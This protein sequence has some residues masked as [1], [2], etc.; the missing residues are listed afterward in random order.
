VK[1]SKKKRKIPSFKQFV[2]NKLQDSS[3]MPNTAFL[4]AATGGMQPSL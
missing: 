3:T 1:K 2:Q 4:P